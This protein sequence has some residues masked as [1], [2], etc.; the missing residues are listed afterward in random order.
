MVTQNLCVV[1]MAGVL[2]QRPK[3]CQVRW[4]VDVEAEPAAWHIDL[5]LAG[6]EDERQRGERPQIAID[7]V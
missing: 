6:C 5:D 1:S 7:D 2:D 4:V 3:H